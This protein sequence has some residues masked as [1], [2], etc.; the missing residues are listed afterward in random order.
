MILE[1]SII[2][3][4]AIGGHLAPMLARCGRRGKHSRFAGLDLAGTRA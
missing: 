3:P 2:H 4:P 1:L